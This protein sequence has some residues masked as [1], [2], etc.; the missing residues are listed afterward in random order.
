[1]NPA[2]TVVIPCFNQGAF[3][4]DAV[5]SVL[6]QT[7]QDVEIVIVNDGSTD[8]DTVALLRNY[9]RPATRVLHSENRGLAAARNLG[10]RQARGRYVCALDADDCLMPA[11]VE[12]TAGL[13]DTHPD[14]AFASCWLETFGDEQ[15]TWQPERCDFPALLAECTVCTAALV[16]RDAVLAVGGFDEGMPAQG[17]EDW[18]LWI[19]LVARGFTGAIVPEVLFRYRRRAGSM[20]SLCTVGDTHLTLMRY[21][22]DKHRT[23]FDA[24]LFDVMMLKEAEAATLLRDNHALERELQ[25]ATAA[26]AEPSPALTP[27]STFAWGDF[28]TLRPFSEAWGADRGLSIARYYIEPFLERHADDV[29]GT[30][31]EVHGAIYARRYGG[32][33]LVRADVVDID[34]DNPNA[35]IVA[36][37]RDPMALPAAAYDCVILTQTLQYI[38]DVRA[39]IATC[40][41]AL[42]PGGVLLATIPA[43]SRIDPTAGL[44]GDYWRFTA[45]AA[46]ALFGDAFGPDRVRVASHGNVLACTAFLYGLAADDLTPAE[47]DADDPYFPLIITV[48]AVRDEAPA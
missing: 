31:L 18:D 16:R 10:I 29:A 20:S 5:R 47:L 27:T 42:K 13:L 22:V 32:E 7:R 30:V 35:T 45:A 37:L 15:W 17:Y 24:H 33:R 39:A 1:M 38:D 9:E 25:Q 36:D 11:H 28:A 21:L 12:R 44:D 23:A 48:R 14:L 34:A 2:V 8:P 26:P 19:G 43:V 3:V 6:A 4:D 41:H 46:R 40:R